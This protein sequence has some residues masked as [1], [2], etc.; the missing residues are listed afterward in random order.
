MCKQSTRIW[1]ILL[2]IIMIINMLPVQALALET[3]KTS[4]SSIA[5]KDSISIEELYIVDELVDRRTEYTKEFRL[6]NGLRV[7]S[8]YGYPVHYEENG[9]WKEID[10]TLKLSDT[11]SGNTYT[12]T[13]GVWDVNFPQDMTTDKYVSITKDGHTLSFRMTGEVHEPYL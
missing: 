10:N 12:N 4:S 3:D 13:A 8:V 9:E 6:N 5:T 2:V 11:R 1:S 7:S